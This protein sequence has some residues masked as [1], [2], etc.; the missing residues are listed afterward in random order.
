MGGRGPRGLKLTAASPVCK[1]MVDSNPLTPGLRMVGRNQSFVSLL[2]PLVELA[3]AEG[4]FARAV[5]L[6]GAADALSPRELDVL[7]LVAAGTIG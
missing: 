5:Q 7:R 4:D 3:L 6:D 2:D 1:S